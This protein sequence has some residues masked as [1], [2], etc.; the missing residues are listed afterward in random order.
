MKA[1]KKILELAKKKEGW[2]ER[3]EELKFGCYI[4]NK[5]NKSIDI[6]LQKEPN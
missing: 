2:E 6:F 4:Q 3:I 5:H 1:Y